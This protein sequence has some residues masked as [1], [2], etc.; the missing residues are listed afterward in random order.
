MDDAMRLAEK[1]LGSWKGEGKFTPPTLA[2]LPGNNATHIY[3]YD[4]PGSEQSQIRVGHLSIK[5]DNPQY[6]SGRVLS[7]ILG[8]GFNSRL[9]KAVRVE[10]GLTYGARGGI[11]ARRFAGEFQM[12]TF[13][14][15]ATTAEAVKTLLEVVDKI[16]KEKASDTE[17]TDTQTYISGAFAGERETPD[18]IVNDLWMIETQGLPADYFKSYLGAINAT[19]LD[20]VFKSAGELIDRKKLVIAVVGEAAKVKKSLEEIAPVTVVNEDKPTRMEEKE[21]KSAQPQT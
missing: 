17:L 9:N 1:H 13:S 7:N 18:Q 4:R 5:R 16:Q 12:S 6:A 8:G 19:T 21:E 20:Q 3:L 2:A 15:T 10:K 11:S 14:K